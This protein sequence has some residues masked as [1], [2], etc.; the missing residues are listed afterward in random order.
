MIFFVK[1]T[2][3]ENEPSGNNTV[4]GFQCRIKRERAKIM[5]FNTRLSY[6]VSM[7]SSHDTI[8]IMIQKH[9]MQSPGYATMFRQNLKNLIQM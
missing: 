2:F 5:N 9:K 1:S 4:C 7:G 8:L 3:K 6:N